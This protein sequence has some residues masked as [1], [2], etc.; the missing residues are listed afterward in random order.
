[1]LGHIV[2]M[3]FGFAMEPTAFRWLMNLACAWYALCVCTLGHITTSTPL[4]L[5]QVVFLYG[6][7]HMCSVALKHQH[8]VLRRGFELMFER[9]R[10][11]LAAAEERA[12]RA[13][14]EANATE[15]RVQH[16]IAGYVFH[17]LRNNINATQCMLETSVDDLDAGRGMLPAATL[18]DLQDGRI[19]AQH[20]TQVI[21]NVLDFTKLKA[22]K[23]T[24]AADVMV[25]DELAAAAT[26]LVRHLVRS[27][28]VRLHWMGLP[29]ARV[30][31][32][33]FHIKQVLLNLLTN[34]CKHT[35]TGSITLRVTEVSDAHADAHR[36]DA[37]T[38]PGAGSSAWRRIQFTVADTGSGVPMRVRDKIF[39][40]FEQGMASKVHAGTG[41]GLP[42][43]RG[44]V[45][46]MGGTIALCCPDDG[47][48]EF[49]FELTMADVTPEPVASAASDSA[50]D[51]RAVMEMALGGNAAPQPAARR[52]G[53]SSQPAA[54][55]A[56]AALPHGARIL[57]A[58][59]VVLNQKMLAR[60]LRQLLRDPDFTYAST[61]EEALSLLT[62]GQYD[63]AILDEIYVN[64]W[65]GALTGLQLTRAIRAA[66]LRAPS[67]EP[68]PIIG[69]TGN[70]DAAYVAEALSAG[71]LAVWGK[72]APSAAR[73]VD[74]LQRALVCGSRAP[75]DEGAG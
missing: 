42:L 74:D 18:A 38:Q 19:H 31:G 47:G 25:L 29:G 14:D 28:N 23:L 8:F 36:G 67:G 43:C 75:A 2:G 37:A 40:A 30:I 21:A 26:L 6:I 56:D 39:D 34:A 5:L 52:S 59:D 4:V 9:H 54:D 62:A 16:E 41:L 58:D 33:E 10:E 50:T 17:E 12:S 13:V 3:G 66:E 45:E 35:G 63:L 20:A 57:L 72:P 22:G 1:M 69:S 51:G 24:L 73:M 60:R 70:E 65:E 68:L 32:S 46:A 61:G 55:A 71:Q 44:L 53:D 15:G 64:N 48:S 7:L 27:T 49:S 11:E